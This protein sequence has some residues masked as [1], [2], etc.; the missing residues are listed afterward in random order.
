MLFP[1]FSSFN[2]RLEAENAAVRAALAGTSAAESLKAMT[3]LLV[4]HIG[5]SSPSPAPISVAS[6]SSA[7]SDVF[8]P[9]P[10]Q[11]EE[12]DL[13]RETPSGFLR[14]FPYR[15]CQRGQRDAGEQLLPW[16]AS[17]P[18]WKRAA[19]AAEFQVKRGDLDELRQR[20]VLPKYKGIARRKG[21]GG[22]AL[23][24][25]FGGILGRRLPPP[26]RLPPQASQ[27]SSPS[28]QV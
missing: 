8:T 18:A 27:P 14:K 16:E 4:Q 5:S 23:G 9:S 7:A 28:L 6:D 10:Q 2:N 26:S 15:S 13:T 25:T 24:G 20:G 3:P 12:E 21:G 17:G 11:K 19:V 1:L 22:G